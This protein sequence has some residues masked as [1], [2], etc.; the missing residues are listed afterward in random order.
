MLGL[1]P[2]ALK[3]LNETRAA[4]RNTDKLSVASS[5]LDECAQWHLTGFR[6]RDG[7]SLTWLRRLEALEEALAWRVGDG[8]DA[9][10]HDAR[11]VVGSGRRH[12][13]DC[14]HLL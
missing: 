5:N 8:G 2:F 12:A 4:Q 9:D 7:S 10:A 3:K 6:R 14:V 13:D 11:V 1:P